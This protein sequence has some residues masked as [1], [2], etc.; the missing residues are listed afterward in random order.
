M[1]AQ[2][3][4]WSW[5]P[6]LYFAEGLPYAVVITVTTTMYTRLGIS[7]AQMALYTSL[8]FLPWTLKA[9]WSPFVDIFSTRRKWIIA[10]QFLLTLSFGAVALALPGHLYFQLSMA[11]F[12]VMAFLSSTHDIAADGYYMEA[13]SQKQQ[14]FFV[15]IRTTLYRTALIVG[16]GPLIML[17]GWLET[18]YGDIPK[19]WALLFYI[20]CGIFLCI[21]VYHLLFLPIKKD[22]DSLHLKSATIVTREFIDTFIA[23]FSKP[24]IIAALLFILLYKLPEAQLLKLISPFLLDDVDSGGLALSTANVGLTYGTIGVIGLMAGGIIG[25]IAATKGGL[26]RWLMPMAWSMSLTCA[27]FL[28]LSIADNPSFSTIN[29]CVFIEQFG[30]G[31]GTTA[32]ILYL[33]QFSEGKWS[34]SHYAFCTGFMNLGMMLPGMAAGWIQQQLGYSGFFIWTMVCCTATIFV[35]YLVKSHKKC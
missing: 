34:A 2:L 11:S 25:G 3:T 19:A 27:T 24:H 21:S 29:T 35:S 8:L 30:Y 33:M 7:N 31:F 1:K 20:L 22:N 13:L 26:Q 18:T 4:P 32:Y 9:F 14:S 16:Q 5:V 6:S 10:M 23:F 28:Y 12:M 17:A 15:G